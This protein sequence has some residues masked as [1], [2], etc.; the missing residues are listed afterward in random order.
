[1]AKKILI[2]GGKVVNDDCSQLADVYVEDGI[3]R[4]VGPGFQPASLAGV[5]VVDATNK[6][7]LPGGIDTHTHMQFPFMGTQSKDDFYH[8]TKVDLPMWL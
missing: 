1:M 6:L 4:A 3:V 7:V 2:K 8:G 5:Q